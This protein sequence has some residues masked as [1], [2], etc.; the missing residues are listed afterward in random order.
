MPVQGQLLPARINTFG[1]NQLGSE[2]TKATTDQSKW[3]K[4]ELEKQD[5]WL[6]VRA[7]HSPVPPAAVGPLDGELEI[8]I[9]KIQSWGFC[10]WKR[11]LGHTGG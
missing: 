3:R 5:W 1:A 9:K 10:Y 2:E 11:Q 8:A 7:E 6:G 4:T